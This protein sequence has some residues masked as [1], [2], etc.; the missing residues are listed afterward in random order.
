[1]NHVPIVRTLLW[2][3]ATSLIAMLILALVSI[4]FSLDVLSYV[5]EFLPLVAVFTLWWRLKTHGVSLRTWLTFRE[6]F[7]SFNSFTQLAC[8]QLVFL[9][10]SMAIVFVLMYFVALLFPSLLTDF[11][12]NPSFLHDRSFI[13]GFLATVLIAPI[14]E[15]MFFRG[16]LLQKWAARYGLFTGAIIA[17]L[18]FALLH[19]NLGF[20]GHF[21]I[22]LFWS[23]L[24]MATKNIW[25]PIVLHAFHN[26]VLLVIFH[27]PIGETPETSELTVKMF[28]YTG[29]V[30]IALSLLSLPFILWKLQQVYKQAKANENFLT[31]N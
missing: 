13:R 10:F 26:L 25:L 30:G 1:M 6:G 9:L 3:V 27:L 4:V 20:L 17:S 8:W 14:V 31:I 22:G 12:P 5:A 7:P 21:M 15:E 18:V 19:V 28:Y 23:F 29:Y 11:I 24:Y 2:C 16:F